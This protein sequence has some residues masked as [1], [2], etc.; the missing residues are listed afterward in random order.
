MFS[1]QISKET[2]PSKEFLIKC[3]MNVSKHFE[4]LNSQSWTIQNKQHKNFA[5]KNP[6]FLS[7]C[8]DLFDNCSSILAYNNNTLDKI[9][10]AHSYQQI[11]GEVISIM[12][13]NK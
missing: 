12:K 13:Y 5:S 1:K 2:E 9:I 8:D 7:L 11:F 6:I 10:L 3:D 4:L